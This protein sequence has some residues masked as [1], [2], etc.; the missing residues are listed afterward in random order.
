MLVSNPLIIS[1]VFFT[2][3]TVN[4][5]SMITHKSYLLELCT[6]RAGEQHPPGHGGAHAQQVGVAGGG[7]VSI[8]AWH[9]PRTGGL[10]AIHI[11]ELQFTIIL[12]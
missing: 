4:S 9:L 12:Q 7:Y 1:E 10:I 8:I 3:L 2:L 6:L 11:L 5:I